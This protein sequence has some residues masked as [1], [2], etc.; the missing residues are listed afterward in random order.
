[1]SAKDNKLDQIIKT[2]EANDIKFLKLEL[3]DIQR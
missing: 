2:I 1:M 3:A